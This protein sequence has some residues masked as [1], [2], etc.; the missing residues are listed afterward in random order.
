MTRAHSN[1]PGIA[2][3]RGRLRAAPVAG[4]MDAIVGLREHGLNV[5]RISPAAAG[6]LA[7]VMFKD[8]R[9]LS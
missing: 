3:R 5:I 6:M 1:L 9:R 4:V 8:G 2:E 7:V